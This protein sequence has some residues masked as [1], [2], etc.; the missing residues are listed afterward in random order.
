MNYKFK[1]SIVSAVYN[2]G[3]YIDEMIKSIVN[4]DIGFEKNV[5]LILVDDCSTDNSFDICTKWQEKYPKNI[6]AIRLPCNSGGASVPRN[7]GMKYV[8]GKYINCTDPD[9]FLT[10][11]TLSSVYNFFEQHENEMDIV[12]QH[13]QIQGWIETE[14][15]VAFELELVNYI[16]LQMLVIIQVFVVLGKLIRLKQ[17]NLLKVVLAQNVD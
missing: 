13:D 4:Q 8:E 15:A 16:Q 2:V 12:Y 6:I 11:N 14:Q 7:E 3:P 1:F 9:D 17:K 5:Q 10:L